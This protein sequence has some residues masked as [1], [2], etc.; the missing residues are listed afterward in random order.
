MADKNSDNASGN[1]ISREQRLKFIG[2][3]VFPDPPKELFESESEKDKLIKA[4]KARRMTGATI[5]EDCKLLE[6]RVSQLDRIVLTI[7]CVAVLAALFLPWYSAYNEF[8]ED[9]AQATAEPTVLAIA[10]DSLAAL[11]DAPDSLALDSLLPA[12][13]TTDEP[14]NS[15]T[16]GQEEEAIAGAKE[17]ESVNDAA[18]VLSSGRIQ[19]TE[20][21]EIIHGYVTRMKVRREYGNL[22]G[23]GAFL[24]LGSVGSKVFSSGA[25]LML[26]AIL[27]LLYTLLCLGLPVY[28]LYG[29]YGIKGAEDDKALA[30][31]RV[32][33]YNW[34]PVLLFLVI[35]L[36]S[37]AGG[38]YGF[39]AA[40]LFA[41][42]G[43]SYGPGAFLGIL[44]W[45]IF[46]SM[47]AFIL[48]AVKGLEI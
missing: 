38:Q 24:A 40:S 26:S 41:S 45:G 15:D 9:T 32:V 19:T 37:F 7:A 6:Q 35:A 28:T 10:D 48:I 43:D 36:L 3:E 46:V 20:N 23:I 14:A 27:I 31:K 8:V 21:E 17:T 34:I 5:R 44:S 25:V 13:V 4:A 22:S 11:T 18:G 16:A 30:L 29:I 42:L 1:R 39:D 2:F 47:A 12:A 33:R